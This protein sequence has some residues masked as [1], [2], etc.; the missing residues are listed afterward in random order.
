MREKLAPKAQ[1]ASLSGLRE[2][3]LR[4]GAKGCINLGPGICDLEPDPN[5]LQAAQ[6][7]MCTRH[8]CYAP[9]D[10]LPDLKAAIVAKYATYNHIPI[11]SAN[12]LVTSGATGGLESICK[13]FISP[14]DEVVLFEPFY[15][16]HVRQVVGHGGVPKYV[17]LTGT[18]WKVSGKDLRSSITA[19]TK[20]LVMSNPSNPTGKVF[21]A[22]ELEQIGSICRDLGV[23]VVCD[24]VYEYI[25]ATDSTH[26]SMASLPGMFD[27]TLTLSSAGKS[28][29][30]TGWRVG[31]LVGP[32]NVMGALGVQSDET[33]L[34]APTPLQHAIAGCLQFPDSFFYRLRTQYDQKKAQIS[35]A[36]RD[37]GF[38]VLRSDGSIYVLAGYDRARYDNDLDA[39]MAMI[40]EFGIAV[41]PGN[42]FFNGQFSSGLLRLCFWVEQDLLDAAC[43]RLSRRNKAGRESVPDTNTVASQT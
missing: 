3:F 28:F 25:V 14:G 41:V 27:N 39:A 33:Y 40:E 21:S 36:L 38:A 10:G 11:H 26:V 22:L 20:L 31:W 35:K 19:R 5:V 18:D 42:E 37:A 1:H 34:C 32:A 6:N 15:Q 16:Y 43:E 30:V 13:A 9:S 23:I 8:H 4:A 7:V 24:E 12:V 29:S 2:V 17:R